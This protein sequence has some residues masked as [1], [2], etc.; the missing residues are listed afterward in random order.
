MKSKSRGK[1][2]YRFENF[3]S[4]GGGA[5]FFS[6]FV[7]LLLSLFLTIGLRKLLWSVIP[8]DN[9]T[10]FADHVWT[11]CLEI[12]DPGSLGEETSNPL[13]YKVLGF[14]AAMAGIMIFSMV[15][16]FITTKL[17][18]MFY[19]LRRGKSRVVESNHTLII[20][21][22]ER[23][24]D[25][26]D[27]LTEANESERDACVVVLADADKEEMDDFLHKMLPDT[28]TT[29]VVT[30]SGST[31][32]LLDLKNVGAETARSAIILAEATDSSSPEEKHQSDIKTIKTVLALSTIQGGE[33]KMNVAAE[34][35]LDENRDLFAT[36]E[37]DKIIPVKSQEILGKCLVQ[38]TMSSGLEMVLSELLSFYGSEIYFY[39]ADFDS[40][41]FSELVYHFK[42]GIPLGIFRESGELI[43]HAKKDDVLNK[44][45]ELIILGSDD[46]AIDYKK[47][48]LY[49]PSDHPFTPSRIER[50]RKRELI[51]GWHSIA[52]IIISEF[53]DYLIEGSVID[54][55]FSDPSDAVQEV[56]RGLQKAHDHIHINLIPS[57]PFSLDDLRAVQP[58]SYDN[59]VILSQDE[60]DFTA[61]RT[62]SDTLIILLLLRQIRKEIGEENAKS[63]II[64]Q[65]LNTENQDLIFQSSVD[66]F[67]IS[68]KLISTLLAQLSEEPRMNLL[69]TELFGE[70][71][72][73][74]YLKKASLY[75]D[76]LPA[77]VT[78]ADM[79][80]AAQKRGE[81]CLGVQVAAT[82]GSADSNFGITLNPAKDAKYKLTGRDCLVVLA[83]DET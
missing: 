20:G 10:T 26:I 56:I 65:V 42:D 76:D 52:P 24:I 34:I 69:Y 23:V 53:S 25:I 71:G 70:E 31:S 54:I 60:N 22:N 32:S 48:A 29:R 7:L 35:F 17:E 50:T 55:M 49:K 2:R 73:E 80:C 21:W 3:M 68:T 36:F 44:G 38:T 9:G 79:V 83:E 33:N 51:L 13:I 67:I 8:P 77:E 82:S 58:Y 11:T 47:A 66:D 4:S 61:E 72:S 39:Q 62:D 14:I 59:I 16:A 5:V 18:E 12:F 64:T 15:I 41:P 78:F 46:S 19:S 45:D 63:K 1:L 43:L 28:R 27:E 30:R 57:N 37:S 81:I 74:I 75:F 40:V 6:L